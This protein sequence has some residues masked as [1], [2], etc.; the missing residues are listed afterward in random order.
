MP[1]EVKIA[2]A[3]RNPLTSQCSSEV[4]PIDAEV[5]GDDEADPEGDQHQAGLHRVQDA[6]GGMALLDRQRVQEPTAAIALQE[7][8][9][10]SDEPILSMSFEWNSVNT[11]SRSLRRLPSTTT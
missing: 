8:E 1:S 7:V 9:N 6:V 10:S 3:T 4:R 11:F 5:A 2:P